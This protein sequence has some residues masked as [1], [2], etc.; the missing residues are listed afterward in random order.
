MD[1]LITFEEPQKVSS[2][3][4]L[5]RIRITFND[6]RFFFDYAGQEILNGTQIM[7]DIP[8]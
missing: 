3:N 4:K 7:R 8:P 2:S 1:I 5:D 6:T